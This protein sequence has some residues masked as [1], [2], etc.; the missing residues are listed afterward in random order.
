MAWV[1]F[2]MSQARAPLLFVI[3]GLD[4]AIHEERYMDHWDKPGDDGSKEC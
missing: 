1:K 4:L 3:A 2:A